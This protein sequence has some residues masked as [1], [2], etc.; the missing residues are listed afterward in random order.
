MRAE[1]EISCSQPELLLATLQP[2][3]IKT[4]KFTVQLVAG[5]GC[6]KLTIAAADIAGL[7]AGINSYLRLIRTALAAQEV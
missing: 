7:L 1:L 4:D 6:L 5:K 2:D 3:I